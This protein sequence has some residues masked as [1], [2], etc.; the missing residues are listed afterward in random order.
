MESRE[1]D[2]PT[3]DG[4]VLRVLEAGA[5]DGPVVV[6]HHGTPG[7]RLLHRPWVEDAAERGLRLVGF[8]RP[9]YGGSSPRLDRT[10]ADMAQD[11]ATIA[12]D[13]GAARFATWGA[14]GGGPHA[15]ACAALLPDRCLAAATLGGVAPYDADGLDWLEGQG[16]MNREEWAAVEAGREATEAYCDAE[17]AGLRGVTGPALV[18][19]LRTILSPPDV[20]VLDT[21]LGDYMVAQMN[22]ALVPGTEGWVEDDLAFYAPW[23]FAVEDVAAPVLL[24]QGEQDLMVPPAHGRWLASRLPNVEAH[25]RPEDGHLTLWQLRVPAIHEWLAQHLL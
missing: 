21:E 4:R 6:V 9:G 1:H 8:D 14:S 10:V 19:A 23:G 3:P 22:D 7:G 12:D 18:E 13:V 11:V 25:L 15:L 16:E 20:A 5:L 2:V 24:W 17:A